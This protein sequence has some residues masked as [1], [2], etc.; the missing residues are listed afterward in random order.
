MQ[1]LWMVA[2]SLLFACMGVCVKLGSVQFSAAEL[3]FSRGAVALLIIYA[4]VR[5]AGL[6][7]ATPHWRTHLVRGVA[8]FVSLVMYF[9][10]ISMIPLATAVTLNYTSPLFLA[11]LLA[12]WLKEKIRPLLFVALA[13]GFMGVILLLRPS[14]SSG[15]IAGGLFGLG[16][17]VIASVAYLNVRRL[18]ELGEPEW[19]TVFYFSLIAAIGGLPWVLWIVAG[20]GQPPQAIDARGWLLLL[21]VGGF[22]ALAQLCMTRAYKH[23]KT[24]VSASLAYST[25]V[26]SSL[27]GMLLWD[28]TLPLVAL[29]GMALILASGISA[30]ALSHAAPVEQD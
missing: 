15:Q 24:M 18:G 10:A 22:G 17:G 27:F 11:L 28:E 29:L 21:G 23:G 9:Y 14:W 25:V 8:G 2:A 20:A 6:S 4:Y 3:V 19:R 5:L 30:T 1:S 16:S 26:F 12:F 7:L 13:M